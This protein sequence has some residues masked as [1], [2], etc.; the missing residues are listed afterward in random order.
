LAIMDIRASA[1]ILKQALAKSKSNGLHGTFGI[2]TAT[3]VI[4]IRAAAHRP[5]R[6]MPVGSMLLVSARA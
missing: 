4:G 1:L 5:R 3:T 2:G 6:S